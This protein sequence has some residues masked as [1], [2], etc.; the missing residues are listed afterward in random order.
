M[1]ENKPRTVGSFLR[2]AR[3]SKGISI[4]E[5]SKATHIHVAILKNIEADD[6]SSI[7]PIYAKGFLKL[8][9][10]YLGLNKDEVVELFAGPQASGKQRPASQKLVIPEPKEKEP[11]TRAIDLIAFIRSIDKRVFLVIALVFVAFFAFKL[12]R[13]AISSRPAKPK[14]VAVK[15]V[16]KEKPQPAAKKP[17]QPAKKEAAPAKEKTAAQ[18][19][20][21]VP[22][23]E[24]V[25]LVVK[26]KSKTWLQ[27]KVDGRV[28][29]QNTLARG[30]AETWTADKKIEM[31]VGNAAGIELE[32]NGRA[33]GRI[34]RPG[35]VLRQ[36]TVTRQGLTVEK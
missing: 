7:S 2:E 22:A 32:L 5:A 4:E 24:K 21:P 9:A 12:I 20:K 10:E 17:A 33:L 11:S 1:P 16:E 8:Y 29:F 15:P 13:K 34:G 14:A 30:A 6:F 35:Q 26:A 3:S 31:M 27:V 25:V 19:A 28:A 23:N 36:V 18:P